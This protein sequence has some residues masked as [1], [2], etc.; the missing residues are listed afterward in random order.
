[1]VVEQTR[2]VQRNFLFARAMLL[3]SVRRIANNT[4]YDAAAVPSSNKIHGTAPQR[5]LVIDA[6]AVRLRLKTDQ[7][8]VPTQFVSAMTTC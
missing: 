6:L 1:M 4:D 2:C 3:A 8:W 5:N 7:T